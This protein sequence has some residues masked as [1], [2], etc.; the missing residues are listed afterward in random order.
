MT[1]HDYG[2]TSPTEHSTSSESVLSVSQTSKTPVSSFIGAECESEIESMQS[3]LSISENEI[4]T[5]EFHPRSP[6]FKDDLKRLIELW[7]IC[8]SL[9]PPVNELY[10]TD[11]SDNLLFNFGLPNSSM[12]L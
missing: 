12:H 3:C 4:S 7:R 8:P 9:R 6:V 5:N 2:K 11:I 1:S 10:L